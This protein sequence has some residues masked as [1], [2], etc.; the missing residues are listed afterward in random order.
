VNTYIAAPTA[1]C[2]S[3]AASEIRLAAPANPLA[4][5]MH[6]DAAGSATQ[7]KSILLSKTNLSP[8]QETLKNA[9]DAARQNERD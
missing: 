8:A 5:T 3:P 2:Y 1:V 6:F 7:H 9:A 4:F